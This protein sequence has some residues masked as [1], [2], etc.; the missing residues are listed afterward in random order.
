MMAMSSE[1]G[2]CAC[3]DSSEILWYVQKGDPTVAVAVA[4][5]C[6]AAASCLCAKSKVE[7]CKPTRAVERE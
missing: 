3:G 1:G 2:V 4:G 6:C 5:L 7:H